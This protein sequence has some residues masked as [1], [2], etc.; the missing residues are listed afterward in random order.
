MPYVAEPASMTDAVTRLHGA[1]THV[2]EMGR[3]GLAA[4]LPHGF[5]A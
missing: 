3:A 2:R 5:V 4:R 1:I